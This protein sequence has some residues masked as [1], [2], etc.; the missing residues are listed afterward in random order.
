MRIAN[1]LATEHLTIMTAGPETVADRIQNAGAI[2]LGEYSPVAAGDYVAGPSH[3]LPTQATARF[4]SGL[5]ANTFL[6]SSS[7]IR[8]GRDALEADAPNIYLIARTEA[9]EA[10]ARAVGIRLEKQ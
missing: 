4:S 8:Y 2:F 9:L 6:K 10:H 5:T 7:V 3:C 1:R